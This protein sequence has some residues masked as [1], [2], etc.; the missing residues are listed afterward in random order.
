MLNKFLSRNSALE[1]PSLD[2]EGKPRQ[3]PAAGWFERMGEP[4][5][6]AGFQQSHHPCGAARHIPSSAEEGSF[7]A[8]L[9]AADS[10][11]RRDL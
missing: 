4:A 10:G 7:T 2:K 11:G 1:F 9:Q 5:P 8:I 6:A 3:Q